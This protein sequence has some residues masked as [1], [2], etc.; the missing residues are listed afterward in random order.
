M[1]G[2]LE[3]EVSEVGRAVPLM[4]CQLHGMS[5]CTNIVE[6][7]MKRKRQEVPFIG[8]GLARLRPQEKDY[9]EAFHLAN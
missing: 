7:M 6:G 3:E 9:V 5:L 1:E 2:V 4:V 8:S